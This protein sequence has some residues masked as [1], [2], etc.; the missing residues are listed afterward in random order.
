MSFVFSH[1]ILVGGWLGEGHHP[2]RR[3]VKLAAVA[4]APYFSSTTRGRDSAA[5][6]ILRGQDWGGA[7]LGQSSPK[8]A[9]VSSTMLTIIIS[10]HSA[11]SRSA[12]TIAHLTR[13]PV[14]PGPSLV[15]PPHLK[16]LT[17]HLSQVQ[18]GRQRTQLVFKS[19]DDIT[20]R[21]RHHHRHRGD[22]FHIKGRERE[23]E[24]EEERVRDNKRLIVLPKN[25]KDI[26]VV[27]S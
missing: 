27:V 10:L 24:R 13:S 4:L 3:L 20:N 18:G 19:G 5:C 14:C 6:A 7:Q 2:R 1:Q 11:Y 16:E 22:R 23:R 8:S 25:R 12:K 17:T 26:E 9:I 21:H 15:P